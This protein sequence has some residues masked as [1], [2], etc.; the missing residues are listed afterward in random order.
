MFN[1]HRKPSTASAAGTHR[2]MESKDNGFD[3]GGHG[4]QSGTS[5]ASRL[6]SSLSQ[7]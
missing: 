2:N 5:S 3:L 6:H 4:G 7:A 1:N